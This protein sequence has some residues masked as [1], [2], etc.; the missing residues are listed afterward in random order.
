MVI[1]GVEEGYREAKAVAMRVWLCRSGGSCGEPVEC[2]FC[3]CVLGLFV[4][5][6]VEIFCSTW[7][8]LGNGSGLAIL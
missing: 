1:I 7:N 6:D 4:D 3:P 2:L 5:D 8:S